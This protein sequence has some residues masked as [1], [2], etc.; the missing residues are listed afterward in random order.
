VLKAVLLVE[1]ATEQANFLN[2]PMAL[3]NAIYQSSQFLGMDGLGD[4]VVSATFD[5]CNSRL[6]RPIRRYDDHAD[7]GILN[8]NPI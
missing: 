8:S 3:E 4:V 6:N 7:L 1:G 2:Q 5:C